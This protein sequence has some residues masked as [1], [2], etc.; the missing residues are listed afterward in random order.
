MVLPGHV[1]IHENL[2]N[3]VALS[4]WPISFRLLGIG[5]AWQW[6]VAEKCGELGFDSGEGTA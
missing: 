4:F 2:T 6:R 5:L 1:V 3:R